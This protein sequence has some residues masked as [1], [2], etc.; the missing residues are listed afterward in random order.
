MRI[1][2]AG[3]YAVSVAAA[4]A[5]LAGC[6]GSPGSQS[7][8]A[9][10]GSS[11]SAPSRLTSVGR[12]V[13]V[14]VLVN[15]KLARRDIR[16]TP[17]TLAVLN[18]LLGRKSTP[19]SVR[20]G[21]HAGFIKPGLKVGALAYVTDPGPFPVSTGNVYVYSWYN[22]PTPRG[23]LVGQLSNSFCQGGV[24]FTLY[25][26]LGACSDKHQHIWI[27]DAASSAIWEYQNKQVFPINVL[28]DPNNIPAGCSVAP[29]GDLAVANI[30]TTTG[31]SGSVYVYPGATTPWVPYY[32]IGSPPMNT[33]TFVGYDNKGN[34]FADG[35]GSPT[36]GFCT[37]GVVQIVECAA[38]SPGSFSGPL[39]LIGF[40]LQFPGQLQ[41]VGKFLDV[42]DWASISSPAVTYLTK[43]EL[44]ELRAVGSVRYNQ[45]QSIRGVW[46][47]GNRTIVPSLNGNALYPGTCSTPDAPSVTCTNVYIYPAGLNKNAEWDEPFYQIAPFAATVSE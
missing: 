32:K 13:H 39:A 26:P 35:C 29:N 25:A 14:P 16:A 45:N 5:I 4:V 11:A 28:P 20:P 31:G 19:N 30:S 43:V 18:Y 7:A 34:L 1:R 22:P 12:V 21:H 46:T 24:C 23:T 44:G 33:V 3:C 15:G 47:Q 37:T 41:W 27:T 40:T 8:F 42:T 2:T 10:S 36:G 17:H 6:N 9:P 38:C